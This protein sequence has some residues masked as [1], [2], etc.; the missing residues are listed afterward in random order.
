MSDVSL[1]RGLGAALVALALSPGVA[2]AEDKALVMKM[3]VATIND[4]QHEWIKMFV[5]GVEKDSGGRIKGEIYPASQLGSIPRQIE[6][7]QFGAIQG[8]VGPPEFLV[9]VDERLEVMS[10][11]GVFSSVDQAVRV[12]ADPAVHDM[13]LGMGANKGLKGIALFLY[14]PSSIITRKPVHHL[15]EFKGMKLRVTAAQYQQEM[16]SRMGGTPVAMTL[17]DVLP[18]LQQGAIDGSVSSLPVFTTMQYVDVSK[19]VTDTG[20]PDIF[21]V[22]EMSKKW[23]DGLA[24]DLQKIIVDQGAKAEAAIVPWRRDFYAAQTKAWTDRGGEIIALPPAEQAE[25]LQRFASIG[26]DLSKSKPGLNEA[27]KTLSASAQR[28][29]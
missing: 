22:A 6:G 15:A 9:G 16:I 12:A 5:A 23:F 2:G 25:M 14:G 18:A 1:R 4:T 3:S 11:P 20:Q 13:V 29:K 19:T 8:W 28:N 17:G 27:F 26:D 7:T 24:P 21:S 10:A